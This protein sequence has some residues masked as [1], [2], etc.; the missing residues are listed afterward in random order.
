MIRH[1][2]ALALLALAP[3]CVPTLSAPHSEA[4]VTAMAE[5]SRHHAHGRDEEAAEAWERA[6]DAAD[7]RVDRDEAE[8]REAQSLRRLE[9]FD[10]ALALFDAIAAREPESRR[11]VRALFEAAR[12]RLDHGARDE[13]LVALERVCSEHPDE[14][15]ASHALAILVR[16]LGRGELALALLGRVEPAAAGTELEDDVFMTRAELLLEAGDRSGARAALEHIVSVERYPL[17]QRWDDALTR[18]ADLAEEDGDPRAAI[19]YL[20]RMLLPR[21][22]GIP[23][24]TYTQARMPMAALRIARLFRDAIGD[25]DAAEAAFRRAHD[26]F[27]TST[28]RDDALLELGELFLARGR[29]DEAC[30]AF[31]QAIAE[32]EVGRAARAASERIASECME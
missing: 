19:A 24:G 6:A 27:P 1:L 31:R 28:T 17:A 21:S 9:R 5:A 23:P 29:H 26:A 8:Y 7:R 4:H 2:V 20:D 12:I 30:A 3:A 18:L 11:T 22:D 13:G 16:E 14:G 10:E 32:A 15:P 25:L